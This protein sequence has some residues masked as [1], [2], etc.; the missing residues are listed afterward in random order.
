M[1]MKK[2]KYFKSLKKARESLREDGFILSRVFFTKTGEI[3]FSQENIFAVVR[4]FPY[5]GVYVKLIE[6]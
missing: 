5:L 6:N 4:K 2:Y 3:W 1:L